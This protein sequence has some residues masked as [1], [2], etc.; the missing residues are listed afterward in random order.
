ME[1]CRKRKYVNSKREQATKEAATE[2]QNA[3][4]EEE[5]NTNSARSVQQI[6]SA[7]ISLQRPT[8]SQQH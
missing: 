1:E 2:N 4:N 3:G 6:Q 8:S 7:V 5:A